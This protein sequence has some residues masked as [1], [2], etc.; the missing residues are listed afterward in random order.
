MEI[1]S[2]FL[3]T[4]SK[5]RFIGLNK[6]YAAYSLEIDRMQVVY[7]T[8]KA[9]MCRYIGSFKGNGNYYSVLNSRCINTARIGLRATMGMSRSLILACSSTSYFS[10]S[11]GA[12]ACI[13]RTRRNALRINIAILPSILIL[14]NI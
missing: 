3:L 6:L 2:V 7:E 12:K 11:A 14:E 1:R 10:L 4:H 8:N 13:V 9:L 5:D